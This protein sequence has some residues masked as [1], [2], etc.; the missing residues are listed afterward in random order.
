MKRYYLMGAKNG[1]ASVLNIPIFTANDFYV[2][3]EFQDITFID[4]LFT[5]KHS[6][7]E[8]INLLKRYNPA[9]FQ[10]TKDLDIDL[11]I[12]RIT[13]NARKRTSRADFYEI[14]SNNSSL[15]VASK[16]LQNLQKEALKRIE[17]VKNNAK[18][19]LN[20][21]SGFKEFLNLLISFTA[22][23]PNT[24]RFIL[25][26][27]SVVDQE[28]KKNLQNYNLVTDYLTYQKIVNKMRS[29]KNLR[30]FCLEFLQHNAEKP[31]NYKEKTQLRTHYIF[32]SILFGYKHDFPITLD[33]IEVIPMD[34]IPPISEE[35]ANADLEI[36]MLDYAYKMPFSK[37][38]MQNYY[39]QGGLN[40]IHEN[41]D[42]NDI[43]ESLTNEDQLKLG[44]ISEE[45]YI[46]QNKQ[47]FLIYLN[48]IKKEEKKS[49]RK[50]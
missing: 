20:L 47:K 48:E 14:I 23:T 16:I 15:K 21:D 41:M 45:Q 12:T 10:N 6:K 44:L 5:L 37:I 36:K 35:E 4:A 39:Q 8:I 32:P 27:E 24:K 29:Y 43:Y 22:E 1:K 11:F 46:T 50:H 19:T 34:Y 26:E 42:A 31:I 28:I 38:D 30:G 40:A 33:E 13:T 2:D 49:N 25:R 3:N 9:F 18:I 17:C 7:E